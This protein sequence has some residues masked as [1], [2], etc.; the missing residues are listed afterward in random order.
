MPSPLSFFPADCAATLPLH[1]TSAE[2]PTPA[3]DPSASFASVLTQT[4]PDSPNAATPN[5]SAITTR[6]LGDD[7]QTNPA[8]DDAGA[9]D[10]DAAPAPWSSTPLSAEQL[11]ALLALM[12]TPLAQPPPRMPPPD[13]SSLDRTQSAAGSVE[14]EAEA[15][16]AAPLSDGAARIGYTP[17]G[18]FPLAASA[19]ANAEAITPSVPG[20]VTPPSSESNAGSSASA[21]T[22]TTSF[23][24][25]HYDLLKAGAEVL[26]YRLAPLGSAAAGVSPE[27]ETPFVLQPPPSG[28]AE[29]ILAEPDLAAPLS[30]IQQAATPSPHAA[31]APILPAPVATAGTSGAGEP[32]VLALKKT[33]SKTSAEKIAAAGPQATPAARLGVESSD[34]TRENK[35]LTVDNE[36]LVA[37]SESAGTAVANW[38][39]AMSFDS[40]LTPPA[41]RF[42]ESDV[43]LPGVITFLTAD[44]QTAETKLAETSP[45]QA[46]QIVHEIR[47]IADGLWAVERQSVEVRFNFNENERL[48]VRVLYRDGVV[49]TTFRTDSPELR[50]TLAREWQSQIGAQSEARPYRVADPVFSAPPAEARGFSLGGDASRQHPRQSD[51]SAS[52]PHTFATTFGRGL[53]AAGASGSSALAAG[54]SATR[55]QR[56]DTALHLHAFA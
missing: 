53:P 32:R 12:N 51:Q 46:A 23:T 47:D 38:G 8:A 49:H 28:R 22:S 6:A 29:A 56:P 42:A 25:T 2:S 35:F 13:F 40:P 5:A 14:I 33:H 17:A 7:A 48:A 36:S 11:A 45:A 54:L 52:A 37:T 55:A 24:L 1:T 19:P 4:A 9:G 3:A 50:D 26:D 34:A 41:A 21:E 16:I 39:K 43:A 31:A 30:S 44:S 10:A 27:G 20:R 18:I 15:I